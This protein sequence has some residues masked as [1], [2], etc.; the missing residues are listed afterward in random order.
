MEER[1]VVGHACLRA[2]YCQMTVANISWLVPQT[3]HSA[4]YL[5]WILSLDPLSDPLNRQ[6]Y[7]PQLCRWGN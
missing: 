2:P 7:H 4:G 1:R 5:T 6:N 3:R